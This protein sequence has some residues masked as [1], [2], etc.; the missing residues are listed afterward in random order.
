M[1]ETEQANETLNRISRPP[2]VA[3][4][5]DD[6]GWY[7]RE[8][9]AILSNSRLPS[10]IAEC[11]RRWPTPEADLPPGPPVEKR[12]VEGVE[13][14]AHLHAVL[15][16]AYTRVSVTNDGSKIGLILERAELYSMRSVSCA[17]CEGTGQVEPRV[18][19]LVAWHRS[20][21]LLCGLMDPNELEQRFPEPKTRECKRCS[22]TGEKR[23]GFGRA[24]TVKPKGSSVPLGASPVDPISILRAARA[25]RVVRNVDRRSPVHGYTL[26][27]YYGDDRTLNSR[28][29]AHGRLVLLYPL[30]GTGT[31]LLRE[32]GRCKDPWAFLTDFM[33]M[34]DD[35]SQQLD[36]AMQYESQRLLN[37]ATNT[38]NEAVDEEI[39]N[40]RSERED[41]EDDE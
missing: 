26:R 38:W 27:A 12:K 35:H 3:L 4:P 1:Q 24:C 39:P 5:D 36:A 31:R 41:Y 16:T 37:D 9:R 2:P 22:G 34:P 29:I 28:A 21:D 19:D 8:L 23:G 18:D 17:G 14:R 15:R 11:R 6:V 7:S 13:P 20:M 32:H 10:I 25:A 30:T 40:W 33:T